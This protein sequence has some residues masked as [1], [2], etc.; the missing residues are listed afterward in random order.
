MN[1]EELPTPRLVFLILAVVSLNKFVRVFVCSLPSKSRKV[2]WINGFRLLDSSAGQRKKCGS[3]PTER[4]APC[5]K[6]EYIFQLKNHLFDVQLYCWRYNDSKTSNILDLVPFTS[7][8]RRQS[9]FPTLEYSIQMQWL[10][11]RSQCYWPE[12]FKR[13]S[14]AIYW[15]YSDLQL[16][17][18]TD[19]QATRDHGTSIECLDS[20]W[21]HT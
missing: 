13:T 12:Q 3:D 7:K 5:C 14:W 4:F 16:S 11:S 19:E 17:N 9:G 1:L 15:F 2:A 6:D 21:L 10:S 18:L 8:S 20:D